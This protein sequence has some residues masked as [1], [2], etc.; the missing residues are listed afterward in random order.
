[1]GDQ[2][3]K[4]CS[5]FSE[6]R[7]PISRKKNTQQRGGDSD[8]NNC[9]GSL[10]GEGRA[11]Q[12]RGSRL[13]GNPPSAVAEGVSSPPSPPGAAFVPPDF[14]DLEQE[15]LKAKSREMLG[16]GERRSTSLP[17]FRVQNGCWM[18]LDFFFISFLG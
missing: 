4:C 8:I 2:S 5:G 12:V 7:V 3:L 1:M 6:G 11:P 16:T 13:R 17:Y 9:W 14:S 18:G 10:P 15:A